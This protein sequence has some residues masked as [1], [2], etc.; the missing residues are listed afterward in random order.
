[1]SRYTALSARRHLSLRI[2]RCHVGAQFRSILRQQKPVAMNDSASDVA[3]LALVLVVGFTISCGSAGQSGDCADPLTT[4]PALEQVVQDSTGWRELLSRFVES[5]PPDSIVR[6]AV[7][8]SSRPASEDRQL[9][10]ELGATIRYEFIGL[11]AFTIQISV[12]GLG[13]LAG[14]DRVVHLAVPAKTFPACS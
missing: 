5:A 8:Y 12:E 1:M 7:I 3:G 2:I 14:S 6:A 13:I 9:L 4:E 11:A 10:A